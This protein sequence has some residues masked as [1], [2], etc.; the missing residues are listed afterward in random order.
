MTTIA[1]GVD[2]WLLAHGIIFILNY[3]FLMPIA[4]FIIYYN[5]D[6]F[7][8]AHCILGVV[9]TVL[10][11]A[12]WASLTGATRN[13]EHGYSFGP[14][15]ETSVA[16]SHS[17]TGTVARFVAVV[18]CIVGVILG[19]LRMPKRVRAAVRV[20]HGVGGVGI[21]LFGPAVVW[22]GFVRLQPLIPPIAIFDST[23]IMWYSGVLTIF[24]YIFYSYAKSIRNSYKTKIIAV[25]DQSTEMADLE[26]SVQAISISEALELMRSDNRG[27]F[28]FYHD[29]LIRVPRAKAEFDHPGGIVPI[30]QYEGKDISDFFAGREAFNDEG[31]QRY[32]EHS[33]EALRILFAFRVGRVQGP[34]S[35]AFGGDSSTVAGANGMSIDE[36]YSGPMFSIDE[37]GRSSGT[38]ICIDRLTEN[39]EEPVMRFTIEINDLV[40][41]SCLSAGMKIRLSLAD[42]D[43]IQRTYTIVSFDSVKRHFTL[44]I[45]I[46]ANGFL[47]SKLAELSPGDSV[48]LSNLSSPPLPEHFLVPH[49]SRHILI[50]G[51]TG[52]IPIMYYMERVKD[53]SVIFWS[54]RTH[55]DVFF[56]SELD[57][58]LRR[59]QTDGCRIRIV[60][61][62]TGISSERF[63]AIPGL[64]S[65]KV[66]IEYGRITPSSIMERVDSFE[67]VSVV[68]SGPK[69]FAE[70]M[71]DYMVSIGVAS[72]RVLSLD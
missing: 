61:H 11:V 26:T 30:S 58:I 51:G 23:P 62:I 28:V 39:I 6:K 7:Y 22:N 37:E 43:T 27:I 5:R 32:H 72:D 66:S 64:S 47:T 63:D 15:S 14:M 52:I 53:W 36:S 12:G 70:S 55:E 45:K 38:V 42:N 60:I 49:V 10:L 56:L 40:L 44:M 18:V 46:Y 3:S 31:R 68:M 20:A 21:S 13:K 33:R 9:I 69:R 8:Q 71:H 25:H 48:I 50:A 2:P 17:A 35:Q 34:L 19:V 67:G 1:Q 59:K 16:K 29:E 24:I 4:S 57:E 54:L 41:L 65:D